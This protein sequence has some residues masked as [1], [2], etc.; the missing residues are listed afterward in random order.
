MEQQWEI[1]L[2]VL[3]SIQ[4]RREKSEHKL[5]GKIKYL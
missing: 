1:L 4:Q 5:F 3:K 2:W